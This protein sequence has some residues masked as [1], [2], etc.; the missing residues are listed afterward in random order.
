MMRFTC[1]G[2][3]LA[4]PKRF[5]PFPLNLSRNNK[6]CTSRLGPCASQHQAHVGTT[7]TVNS[8]S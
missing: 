3:F 6:I 1:L 5:S 7:R 8:H 4:R 2:V